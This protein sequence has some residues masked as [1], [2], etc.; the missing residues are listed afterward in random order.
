MEPVIVVGAGISGIA[1]ARVLQ[2]AGVPVVVEDRGHRIGG[3]MATRTLGGRP[4]DTG[5]SYLTV[6]DDAFGAVV[7]DW[8]QRGL[9]RPWTETF[10]VLSAAEPPT[11]KSG[12]VRWGTPGGIRT[13]VEDLAAGLDVRR[14]EVQRVTSGPEG[15]AVDGRPAPA[16]VLAM[17]DAQARRLLVDGPDDEPRRGLEPTTAVL[18][19]GSEPVLAVTATFERRTWDHV[20]DPDPFHG[21]FVNDDD[22]LGWIADDGRRRGDDAPVLVGH[23]TGAFAASRLED[24]PAARDALVAALVRLLD[25]GQE[26]VETHVQRWSL[27]KPT[28]ERE[29]TH[30]LDITVGGGLLGVCGDGWGPASKVE[31]AWLSGSRLG[32]ALVG[33]LVD[34]PAADGHAPGVAGPDRH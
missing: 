6:T 1:C 7:G 9:A 32:E 24:P 4:V 11:S 2:A 12:P 26:P 14:H 28:G 16:V 18:D 33:R 25:V 3:R 27:A 21:A 10:T 23:S 29:A 15:L 22:V 5:A 31:G 17:P 13:L 34:P 8:Q 30:H 19:R 20:S